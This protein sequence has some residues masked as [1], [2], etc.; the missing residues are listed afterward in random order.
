MLVPSPSDSDSQRLPSL[1]APR[2]ARVPL[3]SSTS[4]CC[5]VSSHAHCLRTRLQQVGNSGGGK[6]TI[7]ALLSRFYTPSRGDILIDGVDVADLDRRWLTQR[8]AMVGQNP[9]L[10]TGCVYCC[11]AKVLQ[12]LLLNFAGCSGRGKENRRTDRGRETYVRAQNVPRSFGR[13]G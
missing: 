10:F 6:S 13:L 5:R 4:R 11:C 9:A 3:L 1:H 12:V 8:I 7:A 2:H